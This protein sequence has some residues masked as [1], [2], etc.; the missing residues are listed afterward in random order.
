[1]KTGNQQAHPSSLPHEAMPGRTQ[2]KLTV[3][4]RLDV[5]PERAW[6]E[7]CAPHLGLWLATRALSRQPVSSEPTHGFDVRWP[8]LGLLHH[9]RLERTIGG[10]LRYVDVVEGFDSWFAVRVARQVLRL[11]HRRLASRLAHDPQVVAR[12]TVHRVST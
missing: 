3:W 5:P 9:H 11:R 8:E 7:V 6:D 12:S 4:T 1:M 2:W 10:K